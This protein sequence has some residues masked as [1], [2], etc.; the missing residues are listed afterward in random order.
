MKTGHYVTDANEAVAS[1]SYRLSETIAIYPITPSSPMA[2][3]ADE[4]SSKAAK[5][6]WGSVPQVFQMQSEGG[7]A[8]AVH[9]T[10]MGGSLTTTYTASQG[11]LLM[12]PN[13]YKIAGELTPFVMHVTARAIATHALSIFG[14]QSDVMATRQTGFAMLCSNS[15]QEAQ[16]LAAI[17]HAATL[18]SRVPFMHFFDGFRTS[19]EIN[20]YEYLSDDTLRQLIE[21]KSLAAF[22]NRALT[23]DAPIQKGTAQNPDVFFQCREASNSHYQK[24]PGITQAVMDR[25][26]KLTGRQYHLFE[27]EGAPNA[28]YVVVA[29]GS[30][31]ETLATTAAYLNSERGGKFGVLK[32]RLYR[33][34]DV[35]AF[36]RALPNTVKRMA[37]LDR[38]KEPGSVGEPLYLDIVTALA[39]Q[40]LSIPVAGGRYGLGSKEFTPAMAAAVFEHLALHQLR[41]GFT[42]GINDDVTHA[43]IPFDAG[44]ELPKEKT[45]FEALFFGLG[46]DGTV[47]A[48]KNSIKIIGDETGMN[49]QAYFVY[50]S[51]KAGSTTTSH[52][53]FGHD[54]IRAPYLIAQAPFVAVH[55]FQFFERFDILKFAAPGAVL[56]INA[57]YEPAKLWDHLPKLA[58]ERVVEK[59]LKIFTIDAF[60]VAKA[61]G[62]GGRVNTIMQTC[63]FAI[64]GVLPK[65]KAIAAIKKSIEKTY[66]RKG[67]DVVEKNF[68]AV[69][70]TLEHLHEV[71]YPNKVTSTD[72]GVQMSDKAPD[73]VKRVTAVML[74]NEGDGL[75][76]SAF[77]ADGVW[78]SGTT[79]FEKRNIALQLP[80]WDEK[81]CIQCGKCSFVCPHAAIRGKFYDAAELSKAPANFKSVDFNS[82]DFKGA[83]FTIQVA[84]ED[85]TG[86]NLCSQVCPAVDKTNPKHKALDMVPH[87]DTIEIEKTRW[88]FFEKLPEPDRTKL[89]SEVKA[90]QFKEPLFEF[91]GACAGCGETPYIRLL[92]QLFGDRLIIANATGCSSIYGGNLPTNP[93]TTNKEGRGPAWANSLFE[94]N[95]EFGYGLRLSADKKFEIASDLLK[96]LAPKLGDER[97]KALLESPQATEADVS[98]QRARVEDLKKSLRPIEGEAAA[99]RL[100]QFA[101][102]LVKK[103][104]WIIG[105]DGWAYDIGFGGL[106]HV[107]SQGRKINIMIMDTEVYSNTGGQQS[108]A[109]PLAAIA[110]FASQGK[111]VGKKDIG[112]MMMAYGNVY[113]GSVAFG[114][115]DSH[116]LQVLQEAESYPGPSLVIAYSPCIAHGYNLGVG[117]DHQKLAVD[118]GYWL[119]YRNDPRKS[120][121]FKL[122]CPAPKKPIQEFLD[123]ETRFKQL[124]VE[125]PARAEQLAKAAQEFVSARYEKYARLAASQAAP[126]TPKA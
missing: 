36:L 54:P 94:D 56:L 114:A 20:T 79:K 122:D 39:G 112:Q 88:E 97:V 9:G 14:D 31:N 13:M 55:N 117:L 27:Y 99:Q 47:G 29:M 125:N 22:R 121:A 44:F 120:P 52:L 102:S 49:A 119:L 23:P 10:I 15:A 109:T 25:F 85:C 19:H 101:D 89:G 50:D 86:C 98:A 105:G 60:A 84:P 63:F 26:A 113:V 123:N 16:D 82:K 4:L 76:V 48:N 69:D 72:L 100:R 33:P 2:E 80:Q 5:N 53:R 67:A 65:E 6:I 57:L 73:F 12:I 77:P 70:T 107:L 7:V 21:E 124:K 24:A 75:P 41:H 42:I 91:S 87:E 34:F 93:Y 92:T 115:K 38:T 78:P 18:E 17:S 110:K 104:L 8:G 126:E 58:Q 103:S 64:S 35:D 111:T 11:L 95:A 40:G 46:S 81:L 83:R 68:K 62:M 74:A 43:S 32:V 108:K 28:E 116:A 118:T 30:A 1:V 45:L 66:M 106:D 71:F 96:N 59:K 90:T 3:T 37:V 61:T 51:R